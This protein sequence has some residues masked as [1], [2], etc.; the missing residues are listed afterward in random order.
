MADDPKLS[1]EIDADEDASCNG[2]RGSTPSWCPP[3]ET[4]AA[5]DETLPNGWCVE[6]GQ[7]MAN[8]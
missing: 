6:C 7:T 4:A 2:S 3:M 1:V 5:A 8:N